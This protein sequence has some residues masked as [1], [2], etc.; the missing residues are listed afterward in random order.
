[1]RLLQEWEQSITDFDKVVRASFIQEAK[2]L[3]EIEE[4]LRETAALLKGTKQSLSSTSSQETSTSV[5]V[6]SSTC[7]PVDVNLESRVED[8]CMEYCVA[9]NPC[10]YS[11]QSSPRHIPVREVPSDVYSSASDGSQE[12]LTSETYSEFNGLSSLG[13]C[14]KHSVHPMPPHVSSHP[15]QGYS[16]HLSYSPT[17]PGYSHQ[18]SQQQM[19]I[20]SSRYPTVVPNT[21]VLICEPNVQILQPCPMILGG[22]APVLGRS[23]PY[24]PV[25]PCGNQ[26]ATTPS[27]EPLNSSG[28]V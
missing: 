6:Q 21:G 8:N 10:Q 16:G 4:H 27:L 9:Q 1:M 5:Y 13:Q 3:T 12:S 18:Y 14:Q 24:I 7:C 11:V 20:S 26:T 2:R 25:H 22:S 19:P 28:L 15:N 17:Y 23:I